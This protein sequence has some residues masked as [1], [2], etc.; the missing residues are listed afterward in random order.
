MAKKTLLIVDDQRELFDILSKFLNSKD[1]DLIYRRA[2]ETLDYLNSGKVVDLII[3]DVMMPLINGFDLTKQIRG[4][5]LNYYIPIIMLTA[6]NELSDVVRGLELGADDY[7]TK[8]FEFSELLA[9]ISS[10]LRRSASETV[11]SSAPEVAEI[12]TDELNEKNKVLEQK[13]YY[14]NNL[15]EM[16]Y[17]LHSVLELDKLVNIALFALISHLGSKSAALLMATSPLDS[18]IVPLDSK[19]LLE[20]DASAI[21]I[22]RFDPVYKYFK[23]TDRP[24][25]I[26]RLLKGHPDMEKNLA[27]MVDAGV[28]L[29]AP[30]HHGEH[31]DGFVLLGKRLKN[32]EYTDSEIDVLKMF[33]SMLAVA[34]SNASMYEKIKELSYTDGMTQL[35]NYR[36]F[37]K[38]LSEELARCKRNKIPLSMIILDVDNF[39]N[40]NDTLGHQAGDEALRILGN[41]LKETARNVDIVCRYGGEEFATILPN[42]DEEGAAIFGER[43]RSAVEK[44]AFPKEEIQPKGKVT[45]SVGVSSFPRDADEISDLIYKADLSLY[46]AKHTGRNKVV[47]YDESIVNESV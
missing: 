8:P 15:I 17:E 14:L 9:R 41:V 36:Y 13:V 21:S 22:D 47:L 25:L 5:D 29:I 42:I 39:K 16:S 46:H 34:I 24:E 11:K 44:Q 27:P 3:M 19:G 37:E 1:Y 2:E 26:E 7:I 40:Y 31:L 43:V 18:K 4:L 32:Q 12:Q 45:V 38:R 6:K 30:V 35:H 20:S 28:E 33:I 23:E 10:C